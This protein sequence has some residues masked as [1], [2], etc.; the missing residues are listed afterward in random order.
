MQRARR[1]VKYKQDGTANRH[2]KYVTS[3]VPLFTLY[4]YCCSPLLLFAVPL[5][6]PSQQ[7]IYYLHVVFG[8]HSAITNLLFP[9]LLFSSY[10]YHPP[11]FCSPCRHSSTYFIYTLF[12]IAIP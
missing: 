9:Y 7:H 6:R 12:M 11:S 10:Y 4:Y 8:C 3:A 5:C 1:K 2:G